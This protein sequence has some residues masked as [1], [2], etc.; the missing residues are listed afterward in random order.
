M[1]GRV[2][3]VLAVLAPVAHAQV[4]QKRGVPF[5]LT[6][7]ATERGGAVEVEASADPLG[8]VASLRLSVV[9]VDAGGHPL[10][11]V[12]G[13]GTDRPASIRATVPVTSSLARVYVRVDA[14]LRGGGTVSDVKEAWAAPAPPRGATLLR[15]GRPLLEL[16]GA[17]APAVEPPALRPPAP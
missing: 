6:V 2:L 12:V 1:I 14:A 15:N 3:V 8:G 16:P 5:T 10:A 4:T 17:P 7:Q 11:E 9:G 13:T